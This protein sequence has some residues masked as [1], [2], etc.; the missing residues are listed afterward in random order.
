MPRTAVSP[1][2][3]AVA[4]LGLAACGAALPEPVSFVRT[5]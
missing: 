3:A 5:Q 4:A 2:A 1:P